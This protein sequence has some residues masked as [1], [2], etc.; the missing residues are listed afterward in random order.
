MAEPR[1]H[2]AD[3]PKPDPGAPQPGGPADDPAPN[4]PGKPGAD[5]ANDPGPDTTPRPGPG[6]EPKP[7][8]RKHAAG[9]SEAASDAPNVAQLKREHEAGARRDKVAYPDPGASP[10][11]TDDEAAGRPAEHERERVAM[12]AAGAETGE[13]PFKPLQSA[14][15]ADPDA[16]PAPRAETSGR[17]QFIVFGAALAIIIAALV[18]RM[19]FF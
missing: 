16:D 1:K 5:P 7:D 4:T 14:P 15:R 3:Q 12:S 2:T 19:V 11:G 6:A 17:F 10:L 13:K 8:I 9:A 18:I